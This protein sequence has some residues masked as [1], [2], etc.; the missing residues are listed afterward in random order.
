ML[1]KGVV[2]Q[3]V[4]DVNWVLRYFPESGDFVVKPNSARILPSVTS[5]DPLPY[6]SVDDCLMTIMRVGTMALYLSDASVE[7]LRD[8]IALNKAVAA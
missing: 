7:S 2:F 5:S 3:T 1:L 8:Y 6:F 4:D